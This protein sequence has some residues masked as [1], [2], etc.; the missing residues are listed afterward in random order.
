MLPFLIR[1]AR[2]LESFKFMTNTVIIRDHLKI[3]ANYQ[4]AIQIF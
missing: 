3:S 1:F 4:K 2:K